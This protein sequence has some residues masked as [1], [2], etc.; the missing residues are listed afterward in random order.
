MQTTLPLGARTG[1]H[2]KG[3]ETSI[4]PLIRKV[5]GMG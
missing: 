3:D 4:P 1:A 5:L 2:R